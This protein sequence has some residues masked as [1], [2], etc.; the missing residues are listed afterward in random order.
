MKIACLSD[1]HGNLNFTVQDCDICFIAGDIC[2]SSDIYKQLAYLEGPF[3]DFL[4]GLKKRKIETILVFGNH[5]L[6]FEKAKHLVPDLDCKILMDEV[7]YTNGYKIYGT[8]WQPVFFDW[9]FN[10]TEEELAEKF[11]KIPDDIDI[12]ICHGPP[13]GILDKTIEGKNVG[14]ISLRNRIDKIIKHGTLKLVHF[15]HIHHSYGSLTIDDVTFVNSSLCD[16]NYNL[17]RKAIMV[18]L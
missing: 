14:S 11:S 7:Y 15:G 12:L 2:G 18:E 3:S 8:P 10:L 13:K 17:Y 5:D 16:D 9:A 6:I 1:I 4:Y